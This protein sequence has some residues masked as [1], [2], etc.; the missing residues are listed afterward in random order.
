[1]FKSVFESLK[2]KEESHPRTASTLFIKK[3]RSSRP[4]G[5][6]SVETLA[7]APPRE[8][9]PIFWLQCGLLL[10]CMLHAGLAIAQS[11]L[12]DV[13]GIPT[14][15]AI[16]PIPGVGFVNLVNGNLHVEIPLRTIT[17]RNGKKST[18]AIVYD[19]SFW[20]SLPCP[21]Q[22]CNAPNGWATVQAPYP[23]GGGYGS[24][25]SIQAS[26]V[27]QVK[28]SGQTSVCGS[29]DQTT[30]SSFI[31]IDPHGTIHPFPAAIIV[32]AS[33]SECYPSAAQVAATDGSGYWLNVTNGTGWVVY[34]MHGNVVTNNG[35]D[36]NGNIAPSVTQNELGQSLYLPS[37]FSITLNTVHAWTNFGDA[38]IAEQQGYDQAISSIT[39]PDGRTYKFQ[40]DDAG[41]T[42]QPG[43]Y[44][45][46]TGITLPTGGQITITSNP[47]GYAAFPLPAM[48]VQSVQTPDG[49]WSFQYNSSTQ[50]VTATAPPDPLTG[51]SAQTTGTKSGSTETVKY[52]AAAATGTPLRTV[53]TTF[54]KPGVSAVTTTLEDGKSSSVQYGYEDQCTPR[55]N[56]KQE[57]DFSGNLI[58]VTKIQYGTTTNDDMLMCEQFNGEPAWDASDPYLG[59]NNSLLLHITDIP[60]SVTVY[61]PGG[62]NSTPI[63]QTNFTYD[64]PTLKTTSGSAGA[65]VLHLN[66]HDDADFGQTMIYRGNP[67]VISRLTTPGTFITTATNTYNILGELVSTVD[68]NGNTTQFDYTDVWNDNCITTPVFAYPTT[69]TN[70]LNQETKNSYNSCDGSLA[71]TKDQ[72]DINAGR[73]GTVYMYDGLQRVTNIA[74]PD[75]GNTQVCYGVSPCYGGS[76]VPE[77][78]QTTT[79]A[80]PNPTQ[81]STT[82][83]DGLGRVSTVVAANGATTQSMYDSRGRLYSVTNPSLSSTDSTNGL[84]KY[85]YD[86]LGRLT[87]QT[88]PDGSST[89]QWCYEGMVAS[90][91]TNC[92][93]NKSSNTIAEADAWVDYSDESGKHWQRMSDGLGRLTAVLEPNTSNAPAIETDYTYTA[94]NDLSTVNQVGLPSETPVARSFGYDGM[95]RLIT[96]TNA[97]SGT[98]TYG[99][100]ANG[101]LT[102]KV[103]ARGSATGGVWY[104]YDGLNRLTGKAY[105]SQNCPLTTPVVTYTYDSSSVSGSQ[106][107]VGRLTNEKVFN[108]STLLTQRQP[109]AYDPTGRLTA[110]QQCTLDSCSG[111]PYTLS[112]SYD[113][114]GNLSSS[115]NGVTSPQAQL[116]YGY[117]AGGRLNLITS[118]LNTEP[119]YPPTL[120]SAS[121]SIPSPCTTSSTLYAYDGANQLQYAQIG[122][123]SQTQPVITTTRCYDNRLRPTQETDAGQI[124]TPGVA[125]SATVT[126]SGAERSIGGSGTATQATGTIVL[127]YSGAQVMRAIPFLVGSSI[128]LPDG[129]HAGFVP[130]TN[131]ALA[132]AN[133]LAAVLNGAFSPVTA[134]VAS[135]GT[136]RGASVIL[137]TKATGAAQNGAITLRLVGTQVTAAPASLSGG[138][139]TAYDAGT[140]TVTVNNTSLTTNYGQLSTPQTVAQGLASAIAGANLGL[141]ASAGSNGALTVTANQAGTA[142]NGMAVTLASSSSEP[143]LFSPPSFSGTSGSLGGGTNGTSSPGTVYNYT[144]GSGGASGYAAN[145]NLVSYTDSM[146]GGL[147]NDGWSLTYDNVNRVSTAMATSGVWNNLT[148]SWSY[149]SFGN[150]ET[151]TPTGQNIAAPVPQA[152]TL[153]YPSQNRISNYGA[154]GYDGAGNVKNDL[155]NN[156]LY[157]PEGRLCAVS[158]FDG[159]TTRYMLYLYDGE[160]RRVAKV[161]NP[162]FSCTPAS[163]GSTLQETYLLGPS[164]EHI[165][166]LGQAGAFVRSNVYANGQLLATYT[167][168]GTYFAL[169]DWLGSKRVVTKYDGTVAQMC[170]N[171]PFGDD[172]IC[173]AN[174]LSEHHFTG[175]IYDQETKN[176]YFNARYYS[177]N[178]GRFMSPDSDTLPDD[179]PYADFNNPQSLNLYA[180]VGNNPL[181]QTD[182]DGHDVNVCT[183]G[184]DGNQ[185]CSLLTNDQ[186]QA[187]QQAGNGGLNVPSLNSVG[188]NGTGSITDANGN[189]VGSATYVS[190]GGADYY[191]N[192]AGYNLLGAASRT[193]NYAT[194]GAAAVYGAAFLGPAAS[195]MGSSLITLGVSSGPALFAAGQLF[196]H[197]F[198]TSAGEVGFLAEVESTGST[199]ILKD[200]AVYPTGTSGSLNVGTGQVMQALHQ[201]ENLARSQGFT[202]LQITGQRL[203]GANPGGLVNITRNLK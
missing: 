74:L 130:S 168:N 190:N 180:Y 50:T 197:T 178:T 108:G 159:M 160:G 67:T 103:D 77:V 198:E 46:L 142:D 188:T 201:L 90:G 69:V 105:T 55:V 91:Q 87:V 54:V 4:K 99:Y 76:S 89:L 13:V 137:T 119:N 24:P 187:A 58:R 169:N 140:V 100:D 27:G 23:G 134:V 53:Q 71:S 185:Q 161:S 25:V 21:N 135:G 184:S 202:Q 60:Q 49:T 165:T 47:Q 98:T 174:D 176:D 8:T 45:T 40:Y 171:L 57:F 192:Q 131:S 133:S 52:Y 85:F 14:D 145:G 79:T 175:Q 2:T 72:N 32:T 141:T 59:T 78:I 22:T 177:N 196:E 127:S 29:A 181:S 63:A 19:N 144:I 96:A 68:G 116:T 199:L 200:V 94:L 150:R 11:S 173:S 149:D 125:A 16:Y 1:M 42:P 167:N 6:P 193:V 113:A 30:Y 136:A 104:C 146:N 101:N 37:G 9:S 28:A 15:A 92:L 139:G 124:S 66:G 26:G 189:T 80:T 97:E 65:S 157:D 38:S 109:Y 111:T 73:S 129:Y 39:L 147:M 3:T 44:G 10:V 33:N 122:F 36:T 83:L 12:S 61:G 34:D 179:V 203:S 7:Q 155:I 194:A 84:T 75:G 121:A 162:T 48:V 5:Q 62:V 95:S 118:S 191:G 20:E 120:F 170:I 115:T 153:N 117:D 43:H 88:Q 86:A 31:Y 41:S 195:G 123:S 35:P 158:Y 107:P 182:A 70:A 163:T 138:A 164:G 154:N 114:A 17:G 156:Y 148:L 186:Y 51:L 102:S 151:Q 110:E 128:T 152:Q 18:A 183:T 82:T 132:T 112:Y 106:N 56:L 166:E 172:L 64:S 81:V 143:G 126:I 93:A